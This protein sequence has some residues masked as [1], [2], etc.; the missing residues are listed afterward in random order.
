MYTG[1][2]V[3]DKVYK[4]LP[5]TLYPKVSICNLEYSSRNIGQRQSIRRPVSYTVVGVS[6]SNPGYNGLSAGMF[7][8]Y[9]S[10]TKYMKT[11]QILCTREYHSVFQTMMQGMKGLE[12]MLYARVS[13]YMNLYGLAHCYLWKFVFSNDY[14]NK[15]Y[16]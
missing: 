16:S 6:V 10:A 8:E 7:L 12:F 3:G 4:D 13:T 11:C 2:S 5:A 14:L 1:I 9:R 15:K